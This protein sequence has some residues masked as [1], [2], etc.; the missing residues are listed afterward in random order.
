MTLSE[1]YENAIYRWRTWR[2]WHG[3]RTYNDLLET[4]IDILCNRLDKAL[5][6]RPED[7]RRMLEAMIDLTQCGIFA[8][9]AQ[10]AG[11]EIR[12]S[13]DPIQRRAAISM[14]VPDDVW[15]GWLEDAIYYEYER[16]LDRYDVAVFDVHNPDHNADQRD[17][18]IGAI[19]GLPV[20]R[21]GTPE[22]GWRFVSYQ[23]RQATAAELHSAWPVQPDAAAQ[24]Y[25][26]WQITLCDS[27]WGDSDL[28][29]K[30]AAVAKEYRVR[31][32][33]MLVPN[34]PDPQTTDAE[35]SPA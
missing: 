14:I 9:F 3:A 20:A 26:G 2:T 30:L 4:N 23:G 22:T 13:G 16:D 34:T 19:R 12:P 7:E 28:F 11:I 24:L 17:A 6:T 27:Q 29:T 5:L 33:R 31:T 10:P 21:V 1:R 15:N 8:Y 18:G 35:T 25:R 32:G